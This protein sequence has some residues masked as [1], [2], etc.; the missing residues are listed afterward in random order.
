MKFSLILALSP[1]VLA[2]NL[3]PSPTE[4]VGCEPHGD[5]WHC[6]GPRSTLATITTGPTTSGTATVTAPAVSHSH[7]HDDEHEHEHSSVHSDDDHHHST[8]GSLKPSPTESTGCTPHGDHWHCDGKKA[9]ETG[10]ATTAA[11]AAATTT[12]ATAAAGRMG[13]QEAVM[14]GAM[15]LAVFYN[16][17]M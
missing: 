9:D 15:G 14:A 13:L 16:V 10:T 8:S 6:D 12:P 17:A 1:F 5:H 4:S 3:A 11:T 7:D 2:Q